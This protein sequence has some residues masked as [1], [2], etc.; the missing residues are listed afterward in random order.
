MFQ[1]GG[2]LLRYLLCARHLG[3][4]LFSLKQLDMITSTTI[5]IIIMMIIVVTINLLTWF[6]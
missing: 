1:V 5:I 4:I 3:K 6:T 2:V